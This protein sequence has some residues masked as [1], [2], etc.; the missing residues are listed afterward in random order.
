M[1]KELIKLLTVDSILLIDSSIFENL[2]SVSF[3]SL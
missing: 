1:L 2:Y 3:F